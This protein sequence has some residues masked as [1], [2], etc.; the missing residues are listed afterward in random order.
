VLVV[1]PVLAVLYVAGVRR[2]GRRDRRWSSARTA[3]FLGGAGV[4]VASAFAPSTSFTGHMVEHVAIGMAAPM[5]LALGAPITLALQAAGPASKRALRSW[6]HGRVSRVVAHPLVAWV[7][8]GATVVAVVFTP[9]LAWSAEYG[10]VDALLHVHLLVAGSLFAW[11]L[12][13]VDPLPRALPFAGRML[14]A[15]AAVPFHAFV[16][17][18]LLSASKPLAPRVYPSLADQHGAAAVLWSSG[19]L[20]TLVLA[21]IVFARWYA[22]DQREGVRL[23]RRLAATLPRSATTPVRPAATGGPTR[24]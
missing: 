11:T 13:A 5:L 10:A 1:G 16:G 23:D 17:V 9:V 18:A 4:L 24:T 21:G 7:T 15:I 6:L 12:L 2:L 22:A 3:A 19:E 20:F 14:A 8:F